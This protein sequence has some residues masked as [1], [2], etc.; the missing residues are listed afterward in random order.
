VAAAGAQET[1]LRVDIDFK[2]LEAS[3][4]HYR[5][6]NDARVPLGLTAINNADGSRALVIEERRRL[7]D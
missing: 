4:E 5:Y 6:L 7:I 2:R 1:L 3:R